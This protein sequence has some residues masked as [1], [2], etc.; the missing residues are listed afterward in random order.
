MGTIFSFDDGQPNG[1]DLLQ[2]QQ[3]AQIALLSQVRAARRWEGTGEAPAA[4]LLGIRPTPQPELRQAEVFQNPLH[5]Q[6]RTVQVERQTASADGHGDHSW[7]MVFTMD[8][9][10]PAEVVAYVGVWDACISRPPVSSS[11]ASEPARFPHPAL[12]LRCRVPLKLEGLPPQQAKVFNEGCAAGE[13]VCFCI[14]VRTLSSRQATA[15]ATPGADELGSTAGRETNG[16]QLAGPPREVGY[17]V[18]DSV[19]VTAVGMSPAAGST[20]WTRG[21]LISRAEAGQ[22]SVVIAE[23]QSQ[24]VQLPGALAPFVQ[25][26]VFGATSSD[27]AVIGQDCVICM[28][29]PRDTAVLPCRHMCL[30]GSCAQTMRS[31]LQYRSYRCPMCRERVSSLLQMNRQAEDAMP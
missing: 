29:E 19:E 26:E 13:V 23:V 10:V 9:L 24:S 30:C 18:E 2:D 21:R 16:E 1:R 15:V 7:D 12:G 6:G 8:S 28:S 4:G 27:P 14:E 5:V 25:R 3:R 20:E 31:R 17:S 22:A 11:S